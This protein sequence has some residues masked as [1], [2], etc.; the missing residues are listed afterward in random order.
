MSNKAAKL[1]HVAS[2]FFFVYRVWSWMT[3][4]RLP[5]RHMN[6]RLPLSFCHMTHLMHFRLE[7]SGM[8]KANTWQQRGP[9]PTPSD[10]HIHPPAIVLLCDS[11]CTCRVTPLPSACRLRQSHPSK[12]TDHEI[13]WRHQALNDTGVDTNENIQVKKCRS[14]TEPIL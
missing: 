3:N 4:G 14:G 1:H 6:L 12:P 9:P 5:H 8:W 10:S 11:V 2:C 7:K 13:R